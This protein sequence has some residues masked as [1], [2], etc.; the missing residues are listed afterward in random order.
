VVS[1]QSTTRY[2]RA[3]FFFFFFFKSLVLPSFFLRVGGVW[4]VEQ[5][6]APKAAPSHEE[7]EEPEEEPSS[8]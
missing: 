7:P 1:T 6:I 5:N 3:I 4:A 8:I 2:H